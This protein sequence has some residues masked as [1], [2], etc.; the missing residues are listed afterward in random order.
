MT[1]FQILIIEYRGRKNL[2][3]DQ[4]AALLGISQA[5]YSMWEAGVTKPRPLT[6][7]AVI[8]RLEARG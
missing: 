7:E 8:A 2:T 6:A 4:M 5:T 1:T 3:Q